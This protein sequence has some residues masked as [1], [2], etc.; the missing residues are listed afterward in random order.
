MK[1]LA[2][3]LKFWGIGGAENWYR[4]ISKYLPFQCSFVDKI[5][6]HYDVVIY[7]NSNDFYVQA[8][9]YNCTTIIQRTTGE[10]SLK[11]QQPVDLHAVICS[12]QKAYNI[13][14][15]KNK[16]L[17][18]NGVDKELIDSLDPIKCDL[19]CADARVGIGQ[20]TL[21]AI[22][23]AKKHNHHLTVLGGKQHLAENTYYVLKD[24]HGD[25][26]VFTGVQ[27]HKDALRYIKGCN[28][29]LVTNQSHGCSNSALERMY[30]GDILNLSGTK[31]DLP[32][33]VNDIADVAKKYE[34][35]INKGETR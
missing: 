20:N 33:E 5:N 34:D 1:T 11:I 28:T 23:Y 26:V 21:R 2:F 8:K 31:L 29:L 22:T 25:S 18:Y 7:S 16:C 9:K 17:I 30:S 13:S 4:N 14:K 15:H 12:T 24:M 6:K 32:D 10:R 19:L 3:C 27:T 35:V